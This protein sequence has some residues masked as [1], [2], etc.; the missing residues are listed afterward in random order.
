MNAVISL[1]L[2]E[3]KKLFIEKPKHKNE[4]GEFELKVKEINRV[5]FWSFI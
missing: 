1:F 5:F 2:V 3:R 4:N